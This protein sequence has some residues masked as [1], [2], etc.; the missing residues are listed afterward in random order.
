MKEKTDK[1]YMRE[2]I[3]SVL[4]VFILIVLIFGISYAV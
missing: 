4:G 1:S 3:T 2:L